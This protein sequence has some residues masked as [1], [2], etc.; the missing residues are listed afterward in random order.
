[1]IG[2]L[3]ADTSLFFD[4]TVSVCDSDIAVEKCGSLSHP[5]EIVAILRESIS[6]EAKLF[7][8]L[9]LDTIPFIHING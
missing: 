4:T 1:M 3:T 2:N 5:S 7:S 6:K 9:H 8:K